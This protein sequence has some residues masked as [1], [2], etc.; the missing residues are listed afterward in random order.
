MEGIKLSNPVFNSIMVHA[1]R[2]QRG[3]IRKKFGKSEQATREQVIDPKTRLMLLKMINAGILEELN[4]AVST[5]KE[6]VVY[7]AQAAGG[8]EY[9]VKIFKTTLN[10]F[11]ARS[12]YVEG[13]HRFRHKMSS[14][15][16]RKLIRLW[17]E[18]EMRNLKRAEKAG[19]R[20]P[21]GFLLKRHILVMQFVGHNGQ[22]APKLA[23]ARLSN[24]Q[25]LL[26]AY[27]QCVTMLRKLFIEC[28]LVHADLS[29]YNM[30]WYK[31]ELWFID[32]AQGVEWDHPNALRFLRDDCQHV[33]HF[34]KVRGVRNALSV[35]CLFEFV[36]S[37][38]ARDLAVEMAK[39]QDSAEMGSSNDEEAADAVWF[40]AFLP[41]RLSDIKDPEA[42]FEA[43]DAYHGSLIV[44]S[45][46]DSSNE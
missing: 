46:C 23:D 37:E 38:V 18:K 14:Q 34:F 1:E 36:T 24:P 7:H 9:A 28:R 5:G 11:K 30:L 26:S 29:E 31:K 22:A 13:E 6:S 21:Q 8:V 40:K 15:N 16:P 45:D 32:L 41:Q 20:C 35:R 25:S 39:V 2:S 33:T 3:G 42:A 27:Q 43:R 10:D 19:L 12:K 44:P 4:G 17:A